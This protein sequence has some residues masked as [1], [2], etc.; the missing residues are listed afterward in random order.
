MARY[1]EAAVWAA[2]MAVEEH[3][4]PDAAWLEATLRLNPESDSAA[5]KGCPRTTFLTLCGEGYVRDIP[6]GRYVDGRDN[7][8]HAL[9]L[10]ELL[11]LDEDLV[12]AST[13]RLWKLAGGA[14]KTENGQVEV[15][16]ALW[17]AR[18]IVRP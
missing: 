9:A 17:R 13:Q 5:I 15:V 14:E 4:R 8:G 7:A 1:G 10:V 18:L 11:F 12:D 3:K 16:V 6:P 2:R